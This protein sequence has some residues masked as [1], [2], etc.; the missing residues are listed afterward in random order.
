MTAHKPT[1]PKDAIASDKLALH[2]V[3]PIVKAYQAISHLSLIHI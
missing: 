3:S 1:N 2:L